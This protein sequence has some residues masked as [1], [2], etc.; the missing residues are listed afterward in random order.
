MYQDPSSIID[1]RR[2]KRRLNFW[3]VFAVL[4]VVAAI[5]AGFS[6]FDD[7]GF[8]DY[9]ARLHIDGLIVSDSDIEE[10]LVQVA[11][12][13]K[14]LALIVVIDSPGGTVV[15]GEALY[16]GIR[17]VA[18]KKPVVA[19]MGNTATSAAYM[20]ALGAEHI[21]AHAGTVTGS[22]GV[23]LQTADVTGMLE[24][25]GIKPEIVKSGE[26]KAQPNP[27]EPFQPAARELTKAVV[28]DL[29]A[30][31][32][33][34]VRERRNFGAA[35]MAVLADGRIFSGRQALAAGLIDAI[36]RE[37]DARAWLTEKH[38]IDA[39]ADIRDAYQPEEDRL[40]RKMISGM[41][42]KVLFSERLKL[43]GMISVWHPGLR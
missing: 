42:G 30:M 18:E 24:K 4:A 15:G 3:R 6:R 10:A 41:V 34:M 39:D 33:E 17:D 22:V 27:M 20:A 7:D 9:V 38:E 29:H 16:R 8:R 35:E 28:A 5:A 12:D 14:A 31:F 21:I 2:L 25:L 13:D 11:D 40:W 43:D 23:I 36:G 1:R 26:L 19:V 37:K 32:M